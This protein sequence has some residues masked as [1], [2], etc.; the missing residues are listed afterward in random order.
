MVNNELAVGAD[1]DFQRSWWRFERGVW[2]VFALLVLADLLGCFGRGPVAH[3]HEGTADGAL[4]V[5][6]DRIERFSTP[7][8]LTI[9]FGPRAI[10][11]GEVHLWMS[12]SLVKPLGNQRII[13]QPSASRLDGDGIFYTFPSSPRSGSVEFALEPAAPGINNLEIRMPGEEPLKLRIFVVP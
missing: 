2:I 10:H 7:S 5:S 4:D 8:I 13:P 6:Y 12:D 3:A 9:R 11:D 1:L